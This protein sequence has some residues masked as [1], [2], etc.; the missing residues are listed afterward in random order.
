MITLVSLESLLNYE[1][2]HIM[3]FLNLYLKKVINKNMK[4]NYKIL[5]INTIIIYILIIFYI[6][7]LKY[8]I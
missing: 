1:T 5:I 2:I 6:M 7:I 3:F 4:T 8:L